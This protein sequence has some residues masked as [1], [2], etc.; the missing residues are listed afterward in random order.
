MQTENGNGRAE[1]E[2][3]WHLDKRVPISLILAILLQTAAFV[4]MIAQL[5]EKLETTVKRTDAIEMQIENRRDKTE[6]NTTAIAVINTNLTN[7]SAT[8][9]RID[10]RLERQELAPQE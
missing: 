1:F 7:M 5:D 4:W 9:D 3:H 8:L 2:K 10:R 6:T